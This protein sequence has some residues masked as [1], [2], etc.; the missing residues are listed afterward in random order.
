MR[1]QACGVLLGAFALSGAACADDDTWASR[2]LVG[3]SKTG[4]NTDTE[5]ANA[6]FHIAHVVEQWKFLFG[7]DGLYGATKGE[8]TAQ[9]WDAYFQANYNITDRLYWFGALNYT[10]SKFSG[11]AYQEQ[12][13]T[14]VG[15]QFIKT[16]DTKLTGQIGVG[17]RRLRPEL[18]T[19]DAVGAITST[20]ELSSETDTVLDASIKIDHSFNS[21]T[22]IIASYDVN[23]GKNNT[24][25]TG[26]VALQVQMSDRLALAAGYNLVRNSKPPAGVGSSASLTT[27]SLVYELK[28]KDLAPE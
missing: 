26:S 11:F 14:G 17:E 1:K 7:V 3:F 22:K 8:T 2:A 27:L 4:G 21:Y 9:A 23:T 28:N 10:D 25:T 16:E 15:Y 13:S 19:E 5:A 20:V 12:V 18:L 24:M 6:L